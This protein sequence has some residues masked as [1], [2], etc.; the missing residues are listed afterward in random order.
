MIVSID[1]DFDENNLFKAHLKFLSSEVSSLS[2]LG[3]GAKAP[4]S[5]HIR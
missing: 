5:C 3:L 4:M 1:E 2:S